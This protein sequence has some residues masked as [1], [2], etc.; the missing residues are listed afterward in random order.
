MNSTSR[1]EWLNARKN[2]ITGTDIAALAGLNPY[3]GP[4][5]VYADKMGLS[6]D[7]LEN[8]AMM[9][10][11]RLEA[12]V[13]E[14]YAEI[15]SVE[16][17][18]GNFL[19]KHWMAGSPDRLVKNHSRGLEIK[20]TNSFSARA[21]G[22]EGSDQIPDQHRCQ[23]AWYM[24]LCDYPEWDVAVL[25]GGQEYRQYRVH[26]D[27]P[28][29][30]SLIE[31]GSRF[32]DNH[33]IP[34]MP[35]PIDG[36]DSSSAYLKASFPKHTSGDMRCAD[37]QDNHAASEILELKDSI[38]SAEAKIAYH[39][40]ALKARIGDSSGMIGSGWKCTWKTTKD[41]A[42][43]DWKGIVAE[44]GVGDDVIKKYSIAKPGSRRFV[45]TRNR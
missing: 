28:F 11:R 24:M 30:N 5:D 33:L 27:I 22:E 16:L 38:K 31:M 41:T 3:K 44:A 14:R 10:G 34:Q 32:R 15:N 6:M 9:W 45:L 40:N 18:P 7:V 39:E 36:S 29:E 42:T 4:M 37:E 13:A 21:W 19:T 12:L 2:Y 17:L 25:I 43:T 23:V 8:E 35:P 20:T 1:S 26:R